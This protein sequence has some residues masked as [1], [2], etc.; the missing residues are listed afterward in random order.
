MYKGNSVFQKMCEKKST[1]K[2]ETL[3]EKARQRK[4]DRG[5]RGSSESNSSSALVYFSCIWGTLNVKKQL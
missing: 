1:K 4:M 5:S 3:L 2:N